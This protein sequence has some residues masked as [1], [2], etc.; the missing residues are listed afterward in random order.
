MAGMEKNLGV[1]WECHMCIK[2]CNYRKGL[3]NFFTTE[4]YISTAFMSLILTI[5]VR[6]QV[7]DKK[8]KDVTH[9]LPVH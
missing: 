3:P 4:Y 5:S 1:L 6:I 9:Q 2:C 8:I 7:C